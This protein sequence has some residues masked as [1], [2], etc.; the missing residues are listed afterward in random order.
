MLSFRPKP[1]TLA[2]WEPLA[3]VLKRAIPERDFAIKALTYPEMNEAV[4]KRQLDFVFTNPGHFIQL[5]MSGSLSAPLS[6]VGC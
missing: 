3:V 2:Q 4:A 6:H 5:K 1:Q